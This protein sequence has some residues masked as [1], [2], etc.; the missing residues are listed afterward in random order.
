MLRPANVESIQGSSGSP[1]ELVTN[2]FHVDI[3]NKA[4]FYQYHVTFSPPV[5]TEVAR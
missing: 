5:S 2:Y 3:E 1:C 4:P